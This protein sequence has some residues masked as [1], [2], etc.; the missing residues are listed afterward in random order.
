MPAVQ[1]GKVCHRGTNCLTE[2]RVGPTSSLGIIAG[3]CIPDEYS[4]ATIPQRHVA[5]DRFPQRHVAGENP[6][7]LLGKTLIVVVYI[8]FL[9]STLSDST[10]DKNFSTE[11]IGTPLEDIDAASTKDIEQGLKPV[12]RHGV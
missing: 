4:P 7:M 5:V 1:A 9:D 12:L 10:I 8:A 6:E 11:F 3:D 2:K